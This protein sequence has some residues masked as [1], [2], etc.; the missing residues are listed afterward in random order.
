MYC[1]NNNYNHKTILDRLCNFEEKNKR[2]EIENFSLL[3]EIENYMSEYENGIIS[4]VKYKNLK[5]KFMNLYIL[6]YAK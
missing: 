5:K 6:H 4:L 1:S 3:E 2:I